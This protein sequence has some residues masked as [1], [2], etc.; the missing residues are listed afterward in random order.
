MREQPAKADKLEAKTKEMTK[1]RANRRSVGASDAARAVATDAVG[2]VGGKEEASAIESTGLRCLRHVRWGVV[3]MQDIPA[4]T[5]MQGWYAR[6]KPAVAAAASL[7]AQQPT[8]KS[9]QRCIGASAIVTVA[10]DRAG[11]LV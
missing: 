9:S 5:W 6:S 8:H 11:R 10:G 3:F 2:D 1:E 7:R 4:T